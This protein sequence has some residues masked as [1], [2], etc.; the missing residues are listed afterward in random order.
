M[1][2]FGYFTMD[3]E[4]VGIFSRLPKVELGMM[5]A[6]FRLVLNRA[7][8]SGSFVV[9]WILEVLEFGCFWILN[10]G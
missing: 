4:R 6:L 1:P 2:Q 5:G 7:K 3:T 10:P 9:V 8:A